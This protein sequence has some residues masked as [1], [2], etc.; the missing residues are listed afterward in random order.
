MTKKDYIKIADVI[1]ELSFIKDELNF[2]LVTKIE[3]VNDLC[4]MFKK[5]NPNFNENKFK[6]YTK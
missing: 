3:L 5:D 6:K 2:K 4:E 1:N